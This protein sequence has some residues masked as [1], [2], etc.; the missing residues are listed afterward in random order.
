MEELSADTYERVMA[1]LLAL[2]RDGPALG[3]PFV[4]TVHGSRHR[5]L[6][7]LRPLG[8]SVR[9]LFAFDPARHAIVLVAGDKRHRWQQWYRENIPLAD[10]RF[11]LHLEQLQGQGLHDR[12]KRPRR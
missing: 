10:D 12:T 2:R 1:G 6:K 3:R 5:N 11:D 4:D 7:E 9:L 8:S